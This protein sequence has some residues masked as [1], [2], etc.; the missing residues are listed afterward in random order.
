MKQR[1]ILPVI[2]TIV[3]ILLL[4][5]GSSVFA[6]EVIIIANTS[7]SVDSMDRGIVSDIYQ[8]MKT[9]WD[10]GDKVVVVM[11]RK[12]ETHESF[13]KDIVG[14][15]PSKLRNIWKKIIFS[16]TGNPPKI[17][18]SESELVTRIA[19]TKGAV[20]YIHSSTPH[21]GV[22]VISLK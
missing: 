5:A 1:P 2:R 16:G 11:L 7:V 4:M 20:G 10:S 9:K 13:A 12:G 15:T 19:E 6:G 18:K 14:S 21:D 8:G 3:T 17:M 22:K